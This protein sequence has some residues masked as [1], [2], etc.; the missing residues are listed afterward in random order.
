M[1]A[2]VS[3][4]R[5]VFCGFPCVS[6]LSMLGPCNSTLE[7]EHSRLSSSYS[8]QK[9]RLPSEFIGSTDSS[10]RLCPDKTESS[11]VYE[12]VLGREIRPPSLPPSA[13]GP[14]PASALAAT[15]ASSNSSQQ[16]H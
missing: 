8:K 11:E 12:R 13:L 9:L 15:A 1:G 10:M 3:N 4:D 14:P 16:Q 2:T 7:N 5:D 6:V